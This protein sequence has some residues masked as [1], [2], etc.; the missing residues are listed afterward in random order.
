MHANALVRS[1]KHP[2]R[3]RSLPVGRRVPAI[4]TTLLLVSALGLAW[5]TDAM[6]ITRD[7]VLV[8]AQVRRDAPVAYSQSRYYNGYRTDCSGFVSYCWSTG[9]SW[10]TRTFHNV[11]TK[12]PVTSLR[13]GDAL[14][15]PGYHIRLFYAWLDEA[16]TQ[17]VAYESASG[18][19][20]GTRV[21]SIAEDLAFGY[22]PAR[23]KRIGYSP[24][25]RNLLKN[26]TFNV[27]A[28]DWSGAAEEPVWWEAVSP[29]WDPV[30]ARR[31]DTY[32]TGRNAIS[33]M[34]SSEDTATYSELTQSVPIVTGAGYRLTAYA[35]TAFDPA[36]VEMY[37][38]Y[39][40][41]LG[42]PVAETTTTGDVAALNDAGFRALSLQATAPAGAVR[43]RVAIRLAG[44]GSTDAS[45]TLTPGTLV[46]LDDISLVRPQVSVSI[47][48]S[49]YRTYRGRRITLSGA[50]TPAASVGAIA[51]VY[52]LKPG[53]T[54]WTRVSAR[55]VLP[56]GSAGRWSGTYTFSRT[57]P[58]GVYRFRVI[59]PA[60][61]GYVGSTSRMIR[62][63]LR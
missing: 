21:H 25:S 31:K 42:T 37:L 14:L 56:S 4:V 46:T 57:M 63:S 47:K 34:N 49:R 19:V 60:I 6:A 40:D 53:T 12:I 54:R 30:V 61:P 26:P 17:Y 59:V 18:L 58:R 15:K 27:W 7:A 3:P 28:R 55:A 35:K 20:A 41:S 50:V 33:L 43:A 51:T 22:Y 9:T 23:Y 44:R 39:L 45:G 8:R 32:R 16:H 48:S 29:T 10:N 24:P 1:M 38:S 13:P 5:A 36:G 2:A 62:V 11:T 52:V